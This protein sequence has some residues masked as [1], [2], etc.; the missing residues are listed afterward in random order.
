MNS[1]ADEHFF[2][3]ACGIAEVD[4]IELEEC[5]ACQSVRYCSDKCREEHQQQ[6]DEE[7]KKRVAEL[8][9]EILFRQPESSHYG[10]C[11]I[12]F[13]P[14]CRLMIKNLRCGHA[15]AK[16]FVMAVLLPI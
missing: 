15:A 5:D 8:H 9:D 12:C 14:R 6:H 13:L 1:S 3:A 2:C 11:P 10:D 7:C 16:L 4:N